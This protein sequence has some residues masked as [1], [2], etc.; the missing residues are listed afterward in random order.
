MCPGNSE[1]GIALVLNC[2]QFRTMKVLAQFN[3]GFTKH[4]FWW[5]KTFFMALTKHNIF[6]LVQADCCR[7][8]SGKWLGP[9][10][11]RSRLPR[12]YLASSGGG[13][14]VS[15][16]R[17]REEG[18]SRVRKGMVLVEGKHADRK[19]AHRCARDIVGA[20]R[21][22]TSRLSWV[23]LGQRNKCSLTFRRHTPGCQN[24]LVEYRWEMWLWLMK[25]GLFEL[26]AEWWIHQPMERIYF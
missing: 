1:S 16:G 23:Y 7:P 25:P 9:H 2:L 12:H 22:G 13:K 11:N 10:V 8:T 24:S 5:H 6:H 21:I 3:L 4:S 18:R 14:E 15:K 19:H 20:S 26:P 17:N